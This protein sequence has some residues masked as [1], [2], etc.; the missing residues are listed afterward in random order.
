M[1]GSMSPCCSCKP[2]RVALQAPLQA[3]IHHTSSADRICCACAAARFVGE[4][5]QHGLGQQTLLPVTCCRIQ[6]RGPLF[7]AFTN[8]LNERTC[9]CIAGTD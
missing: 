6:C 4:P 3:P 7:D 1:L 8:A 5:K 2:W 9:T